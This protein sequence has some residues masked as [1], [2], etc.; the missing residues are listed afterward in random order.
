MIFHPTSVNGAYVVE[1]EKIEDDRGFF[2]RVWC[3]NQFAERGLKAEVA[4]ANLSYNVEKGTLRG[5]HFQRPPHEEAKLVRC[6]VGAV[7]DVLVDLRPQSRSYKQWFGTELTNEN[8]RMLYV[9][10]CC[11]HGYLT[12]TDR[13]EVLYLV[14]AF[15]EPKAE[16]GL[17]FDDPEFEIKW[18]VQPQIISTKDRSWPS[19]SSW[20]PQEKQVM[21]VPSDD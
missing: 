17:R 8:H 9:P 5:M 15:Y 7:Y 12:L 13:A 14:S 6:T 18:P 3:V 1:P 10:P 4:Q 16:G 21:Q 19:Y 2:A 20:Q 11:A